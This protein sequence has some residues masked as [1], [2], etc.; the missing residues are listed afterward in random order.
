MI[1]TCP[2]CISPSDKRYQHPDG[3]IFRCRDCGHAFTSL[4]SIEEHETYG[5]TYYENIHRNWFENPNGPL[6]EWIAS[7]IDTA[8]SVLDV[9]CGKGDFLR[10]LCAARRSVRLVGVDL[11]P[12]RDEPGIAYIEGDILNFDTDTKFDAV[13][14]LAV[15]EHVPDVRSFV[16]SIADKCTPN[17]RVIVMTLN[18]TGMLYRCARLGRLLG[19]QKPFDRLY[20]VHHLHH[21]TPLSLQ[22]V[23]TGA[24]LTVETTHFHNAPMK[25]IDVPAGNA[26]QR[27]IFRLSVAVIFLLGTFTGSTYLQTCVARKGHE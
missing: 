15:I 16:K 6:F 4:D 3:E 7:H 11:S 24:G 8:T 18:E 19:I 5:A 14:S 26:I 22:R 10:Y 21:F 12:N 17:G 23:L 2:I 27:F 9:G 20:S 25:S 13:V 1:Q